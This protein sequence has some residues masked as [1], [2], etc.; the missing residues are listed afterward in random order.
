[1]RRA[2]HDGLVAGSNTF[3]QHSELVRNLLICLETNFSN[4]SESALVLQENQSGFDTGLFM[5]S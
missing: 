1:V 4:F 2:A 5:R 3:F